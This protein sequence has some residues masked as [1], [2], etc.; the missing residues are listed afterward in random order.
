MLDLDTIRQSYSTKSFGK[1][2]AHLT[3]GDLY[4]LTHELVNT[5]L[6]IIADATDA[7]VVFVPNDPKANDEFGKPED[8]F[9]SWT[10][11]HIVV[12]TT[13]SSEESASLALSLARGVAVEGRSRYETEWTTVHSVGQCRERL[14]ESRRMRVA[15]LDA[16]PTTPNLEMVYKTNYAGDMN[17]I[18]R[19]VS[20]LSHEQGHLKQLAEAIRQA[21]AAHGA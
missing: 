12:H 4:Q 6:A 13:A 5:Q 20:G 15:M 19:F 1:A 7:D 3:K 9:I 21:K 2:V 14:E 10:A 11:A 8:K 17:A 18:A 16:W